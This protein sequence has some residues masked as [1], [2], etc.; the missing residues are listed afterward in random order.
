MEAIELFITINKPGLNNDWNKETENSLKKI[1]GVESVIIIEQNESSHAQI[2]IS[3]NIETLSLDNVESVIKN[4]GAAIVEIMVHFPSGIS[5]VSDPYGASEMATSRKKDM[6]K[7]NGVLQLGVS[8]T[9]I[10]KVS[11]DPAVSN[12]QAIVDEIIQIVSSANAGKN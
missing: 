7:I 12:K 1:T 5:G 6:N 8:S 9:G 11:L 3:Y 2:N 10:L 4:I